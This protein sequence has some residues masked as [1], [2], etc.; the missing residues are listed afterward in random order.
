MAKAKL[1]KA[2]LNWMVV[3]ENG[4]KIMGATP[5]MATE[6]FTALWATHYPGIPVPEI[7]RD[8]ALD[9]NTAP[10]DPVEPLSPAEAPAPEVKPAEA[11]TG[12]TGPE[13]SMDQLHEA[14]VKGEKH[15]KLYAPAF[16]HP[17]LAPN[18]EVTYE[19][20]LEAVRS[21][22]RGLSATTGQQVVLL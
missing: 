14:L 4:E 1:Y 7:E 11:T 5:E 22:E 18:V 9:I 21:L 12:L 16:A 17:L 19:A 10:K 8:E 2:N 3:G 15:Q 20:A 13:F 6:A